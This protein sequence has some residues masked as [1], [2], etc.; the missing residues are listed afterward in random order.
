LN[1]NLNSSLIDSE[2]PR[3][4]DA[5]STPG[6][7]TPGLKSKTSIKDNE[8]SSFELAKIRLFEFF[9]FRSSSNGNSEPIPNTKYAKLRFFGTDLSSNEAK[10]L[11]NDIENF[12]KILIDLIENFNQH[13]P[14]Q[15]DGLDTEGL[16]RI[17]ASKAILQDY[18]CLID[19]N[20]GNTE[21]YKAKLVKDVTIHNLTGLL[22]LYLREFEK[23]LIESKYLME[24][25]NFTEG[26]STTKDPT[27]RN[28]DFVHQNIFQKL[29]KLNQK[30]L[31]ILL[32][33]LIKIAQHKNQM[34]LSN[35]AKCFSPTLCETTFDPVWTDPD[36]GMGMDAL[37]AMA[38]IQTFGTNLLEVMLEEEFC[39]MIL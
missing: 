17:N 27:L 37:Q 8:K 13:H 2:S 4:R 28:I 6:S 38:K 32:P 29:P 35:L 10:Q 31:T 18:R 20:Y 16:Y 26:N 7:T 1:S 5:P 22:K 25:N 14:D 33:H 12:L 30:I 36:Q 15:P 3:D 24:F 34:D 21:K 23:P 11:T 19:E 9:S 39:E